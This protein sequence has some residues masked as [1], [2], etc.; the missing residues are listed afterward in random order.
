MLVVGT[1]A[2]VQPA[3]NLPFSAKANGATIIEINLEP[4]PVSS[5]ADVSLFGKAGEIMPILW[6]KIKGED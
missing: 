4:T 1:S 6:N 3:A 2:L 5:I